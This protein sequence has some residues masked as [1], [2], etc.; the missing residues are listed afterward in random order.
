LLVVMV[1]VVTSLLPSSVR[2]DVFGKS[3]ITDYVKTLK[4][5]KII[6]TLSDFQRGLS[7]YDEAGFS[8]AT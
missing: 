5:T 3:S 1:V 4:E 8:T 2:V 6:F 7:H